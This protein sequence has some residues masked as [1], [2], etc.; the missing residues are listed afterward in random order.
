[1]PIV[2]NLKHHLTGRSGSTFT[3]K[4]QTL[5]LLGDY[6]RVERT[7]TSSTGMAL[8]RFL[9]NHP[10]VALNM[11]DG[12]SVDFDDPKTGRRFRITYYALNL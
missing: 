11:K 12:E 6:E 3:Y 10:D 4:V 8:V 5:R 2:K 9:A 7:G 1:M